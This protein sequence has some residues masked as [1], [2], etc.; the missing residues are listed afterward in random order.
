MEY[1]TALQ[2]GKNPPKQFLEINSE[3]STEKLNLKDF[4]KEL[5]FAAWNR[6]KHLSWRPFSEARE[7]AR[8]LDLEG[9]ADWHRF[10]K[11]KDAPADIP[12]HPDTSNVYKGEWTNWRDFLGNPTPEEE[13]E[14]Y[15]SE[16]KSMAD[17][18]DLKGKPYFPHDN[19]ITTNDYSLGT[20]TRSIRNS[21]KLEKIPKWKKDR[22]RE[23]LGDLWSDEGSD[24]W[25]WNKNYELYVEW[26]ATSNTPFFP[27][28]KT[29][30]GYNLSEWVATQNRQLN[31]LG[32]WKKQDTKMRKE[33][34]RKLRKLGFPLP[35]KLDYG[36]EQMYK[37]AKLLLVKYKGRIPV[38]NPDTDK[39]YK[40]NDEVDLRTWITKQRGR[41]EEGILK[42][43]RIE[44]LES[45]R[46]WSWN[47]FKDSFEK[48]Y[49]LLIEYISK[50]K[51]PNPQQDTKYKNASNGVFLT[52]LRAGDYEW[53]TKDM[54]KQLEKLGT[55]F[56]PTK[57]IGAFTYYD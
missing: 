25:H 16:F 38:K 52:G 56:K 37:F 28:G 42:Q 19:A 26:R 51:N 27:H 13:L 20:L 23:A 29:Y 40:L 9:H 35:N 3:Y 17:K 47:P 53:F 22:L 49:A 8:T 6:L 57:K 31:N 54:K 5:S 45:L 55:N 15:I 10:K 4:E 43:E 14:I 46:Y 21:I 24:A 33:R 44:K 39:P 34:E 7:Y 41:Y 50:K 1:F 36:W 30:Q 48:N 12:H 18:E 11:T 2:E 32:K